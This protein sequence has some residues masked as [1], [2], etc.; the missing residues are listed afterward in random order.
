MTT[1]LTPT[2]TRIAILLAVAGAAWFLTAARMDDMGMGMAGE[3]GGLGWFTVTWVAMMAAMM[4]PALGPAV[5]RQRGSGVVFVTGYLL[6]WTAAGVLGYAIVDATG[7]PA[8]RAAIV[9]ILGAAAYQ[10]TGAK[11]A[12]L[13]RCRGDGAPAGGLEYAGYCVSCCWA[14]MAA[15][16]ALGVMSLGWMAVIAALITAERLLPWRRAT[17]LGVAAVLLVLSV[18]VALGA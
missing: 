5:I 4:L 1:L 15:L 17:V 2:R 16:F 3:L 18:A 12:A 13:R 7:I 11:D 6:P 8:R 10:L 14:M 9:V